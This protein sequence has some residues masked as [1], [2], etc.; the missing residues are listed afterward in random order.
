M[1]HLPVSVTSAGGSVGRVL[2]A[3]ASCASSVVA[4]A[5]LLP[6]GI[7]VG[8]DSVCALSK[9][10]GFVLTYMGVCFIGVSMLHENKISFLKWRGPYHTCIS[11]LEIAAR[12]CECDQN[13]LKL[14]RRRLVIQ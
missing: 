3:C 8:R 2:G 9:D 12:C 10:T 4:G 5:T 7:R 1:L 11:T 6:R 14:R 13:S